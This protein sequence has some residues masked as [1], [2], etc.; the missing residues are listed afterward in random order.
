MIH[1][2]YHTYG[3]NLRNVGSIGLLGLLPYLPRY[4]IAQ[5]I[6]D[7]DYPQTQDLNRLS[8]ILSF[9]AN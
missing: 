3:G 1:E 4:G 8:S 7:S 9:V 5:V 6:V 2:N